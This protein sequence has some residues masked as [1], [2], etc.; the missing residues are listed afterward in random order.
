MLILFLK[1]L[2]RLL[3]FPERIIQVNVLLFDQESKSTG[4]QARQFCFGKNL[5]EFC[6]HIVGIRYWAKPKIF[7]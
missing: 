2:I 3:L 6:H 5:L 1:F 4:K 7:C